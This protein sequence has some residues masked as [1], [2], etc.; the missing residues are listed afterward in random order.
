MSVHDRLGPVVR[1]TSIP[2]S[3]LRDDAD[4]PAGE[5]QLQRCI[6]AVDAVLATYAP[7]FTVPEFRRL[8]DRIVDNLNPAGPDTSHERRYLHLSRLADGSLIGKFACGPEQALSLLS[9]INAGSA[10]QPGVAVDAD[11]VEHRIR[12]ERTKAQRDLDA[13]VDAV[14]RG[15][16]HPD[17]H[18][19]A[20]HDG[21]N[22][23]AAGTTDGPAVIDDTEGVGGAGQPEEV[24]EAQVDEVRQRSDAMEVGESDRVADAREFEESDGLF[25]PDTPDD[26]DEPPPPDGELE[27]RRHAG[28]RHGSYPEPEI[29][30]IATL[31]QVAHARARHAADSRA[32]FRFTGDDPDSLL[33]GPGNAYVLGVGPILPGT[34][35]MLACAGRLLT[36]V[37]DRHG[38]VLDLGRTHRL[39]TAAQRRALDARDVGCVIPGCAVPGSRCEVHH[40]LAWIDGGPTDLANLYHVCPRHHVEVGDGTWE[41]V[42]IDGVP[43]VRPPAWVHPTRPLLRNITH[44]IPA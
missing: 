26:A 29:T 22:G 34:L 30:V 42:M 35:A 21:E 12:D 17:D 16:P 41:I 4:R 18:E 3:H 13:L 31:D 43:W 36:A 6:D 44:R 2:V 32:G 9:V 40:V 25:E 19:H 8:A 37:L 15:C 7:A 20:G 5:E 23:N 38:A 27:I 11:G 14:H 10:P 28:V 33:G 1:E 39:A 24:D